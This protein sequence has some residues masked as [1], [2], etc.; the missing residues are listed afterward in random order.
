MRLSSTSYVRMP[1]GTFCR[2]EVSSIFC[3]LEACALDS[4]VYSKE[5]TIYWDS[6]RIPSFFSCNVYQTVLG[7][8]VILLSVYVCQLLGIQ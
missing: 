2:V 3:N 5:S 4:F 1:E 6:P 8:L 7:A